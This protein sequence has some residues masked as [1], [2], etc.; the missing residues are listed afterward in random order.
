[1]C[2]RTQPKEEF[3]TFKSCQSCRKKKSSKKEVKVEEVKETKESHPVPI[4]TFALPSTVSNTIESPKWCL[5][6][7]KWIRRGEEQT[8][9][10]ILLKKVH[11][12]FHRRCAFPIH[13]YLTK[14]LMMDIRDV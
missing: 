4:E 7:G 10:K 8:L 13:K 1:V 2:K 11:N 12:Q 6:S 3:Q 9:H 14:Y 5:L